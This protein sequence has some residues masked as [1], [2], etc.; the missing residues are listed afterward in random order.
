MC[1][2]VCAVVACKFGQVTKLQENKHKETAD[3]RE[4]DEMV[5]CKLILSPSKRGGN[6]VGL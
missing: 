5:K 6:S 2:F 3:K 1:A 4:H